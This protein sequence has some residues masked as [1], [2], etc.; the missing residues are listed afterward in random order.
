MYIVRIIVTRRLVQPWLIQTGQSGQTIRSHVISQSFKQ[1]RV[2]K[3]SNFQR[4]YFE[5][6]RNKT[7]SSTTRQ[8]LENYSNA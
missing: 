5:N 2:N 3:S 4:N 7:T 8:D 1:T 6:F